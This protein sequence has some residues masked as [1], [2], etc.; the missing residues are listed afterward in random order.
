MIR[1]SLVVQ[2][3]GFHASTAGSTGWIPGQG[4]KILSAVWCGP[5]TKN[6]ASDLVLKETKT[7]Y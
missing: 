4:T 2:W 7:S 5:K 3:L 6:L 1:S